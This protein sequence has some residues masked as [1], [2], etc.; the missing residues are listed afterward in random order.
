MDEFLEKLQVDQRRMRK[1]LRGRGPQFKKMGKA[2]AE[3]RR[4]GTR[5][6]LVGE[7]PMAG[8]MQ[9]LA[10]EY[11]THLPALPVDLTRTRPPSVDPDSERPPATPREAAALQ[12]GRHLHEG[13]LVLAYL[14]E[15]QDRPTLALLE[16]AHDRGAKV[17]VIGGLGAKR[18]ARKHAKLVLTLPTR[19]IKTVCEASFVATRIL[20]R[21]SRATCRDGG[22]A[23]E[24][25]LIQVTCELCGE[26][27]FFEEQS[28]GKQERCPLCEANV[29]VPRESGRRTT[30]PVV[31]ERPAPPPGHRRPKPSVLEV[32]AIDPDALAAA[33]APRGLISDETTPGDDDGELL[34]T[35]GDAA[36][37][38]SV[39]ASA[40]PFA[41]EDGF[42]ADLEM[43]AART[44]TPPPSSDDRVALPNAS[45][46]TVSA[47]YTIEQ[48]RLRW[49]RGGF[50]DDDS[51]EHRLVSFQR[52]G[53][54]FLL[55]P[56]DPAGATLQVDD[57]LFVRI[58]IPAFLEP[59][60]VRAVLIQ[61][62]GSTGGSGDGSR[63]ELEFRDP[64]ATVRRKLDRAAD[65]LRAPA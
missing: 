14:H 33:D 52:T 55:R 54:E 44:A 48:C 13:D 39:T 1:F 6:F 11:L 22:L 19:G 40:D 59:I 65:N 57:E 56:D 21:V 60:L 10:E 37:S 36:K 24:A 49:G 61:I 2:L 4:R 47:R 8:L 18:A 12:V 16:A 51:P 5:L 23:E 30:P 28:R 34:S 9:I 35:G 42:L 32:K 62:S 27:V 41:L 26:R 45:R 17:M 25:R 53:L 50:P 15:G 31:V 46:R 29:A 63:A 38:P 64:D 7:P 43:P 3:P 20:A 58:E